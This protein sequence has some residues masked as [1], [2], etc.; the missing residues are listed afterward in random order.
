MMPP[1]ATP[2]FVGAL[3]CKAGG[4]NHHADEGKRRAQVAGHFAAGDEKKIR[5]PIPL[6]ST[7]T[8]G[9]KPMRMGASTVELKHGDHVLNAHQAGLCPGQALIRPNDAAALQ[10]GWGLFSP[11]KHSHLY[12]SV[13]IAGAMLEAFARTRHRRAAHTCCHVR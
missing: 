10:H 1:S 13:K 11:G 9:S 7:A 3:A 2:M 4:G 8:L 12:R 5:V 6:I